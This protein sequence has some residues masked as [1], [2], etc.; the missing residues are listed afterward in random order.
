MRNF[1][2]WPTIGNSLN[3]VFVGGMKVP[4]IGHKISDIIY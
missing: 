3:I 4:E 1:S 2:E